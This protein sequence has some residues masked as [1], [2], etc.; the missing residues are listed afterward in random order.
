MLKS[1]FV[2][3]ALILAVATGPAAWAAD[4]T[5]HQVYQALVSG[6][7]QEAQQMIDQVL[8]DR[9]DSGEAH[10]I[11]AEVAA[12]RGNFSYARTELATA[13]R[14]EPGLPFLKDPSSANALRR[15]LYGGGGAV[16]PSP[17]IRVQQPHSSGMSWLGWAVIFG[18][19]IVLWMI[20]RRAFA[21]RVYPG[22]VPGPMGMSGPMGGGPMMGGG[23]GMG[24]PPAGGSGI[25]GGLASGLAIGAG[26]AAGEELVH[27][28]LD[29][30]RGDGGGFIPSAG[31]SEVNYPDNTNADMGGADFGVSDSSSWDDSSGGGGFG[32]GDDWS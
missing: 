27:H 14:L 13:E 16:N 31:A 25:L 19:V 6:H 11:A 10:Y 23:Y 15:Q 32:G 29:G 21:P 1:T 30:N 7:L 26:V 28:V 17:V 3:L 18:G 12:K 2:T 9:P 24:P 8:K 22:P 20:L 4:P 5:P